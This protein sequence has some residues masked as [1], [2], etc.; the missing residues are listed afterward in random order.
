[1]L[2][3]KFTLKAQDALES[4]TRLAVKLG[5]KHVTP[6][7]LL[8]ACLEQTDG[9]ARRLLTAGHADLE[10][11]ARSIGSLVSATEPADKDSKGTPI[12]R[13]LERVF[14]IAEE[15]A[16]QLKNRY[17]GVHHLLLGLL[18]DSGV[19]AT[20][21]AAGARTTDLRLA[22][23]GAGT[24]SPRKG[25]PT[26]ADSEYLSKYTDD[27]TRAAREG[28]LDPVI[29]RGPEIR[30][31]LQ[32]LN[33][34][35]KNNPLLVG[36]PG[37]G[38]TAVV[39]GLAQRIVADDVPDNLRGVSLLALDLGQ[40]V[41]GTKFRGEFEKRLKA[42][43]NEA[44]DAENVILFIDEIHMIIGAGSSEGSMDASNLL[45]PA[46]SR[47]QI[48][49]VGATTV[50]E[51]RKH[52]EK[53]AALTRRFQRV[54]VNEPD[55]E[56]AINILRGLKETYEAHHGVRVLD[57]AI[58]AAVKLSD[59]YLTDRFLPDKAIDLLDETASS[60]RMDISSKPGEIEDLDRR[61]IHLEIE[62]TALEAEGL[63]TTRERRREI[64]AELVELRARSAELTEV[65]LQE[66]RAIFDLGQVKA[67]LEAARREM[68]Q[69]IREEDFAR[70]AELQYKII[71][72]R[73]QA[74]AEFDDVEVG[75][76]R[77][78][79][80]AV[81]EEDIARTLSR[82]TGIPVD[83]MLDS[84]RER[85]LQMETLMRRRVIGQE[86]ALTATAKAL[87]RSRAGLQD[88][89][90]PIASFLM[91]GPTGVGKTE[92]SKAL[93][94]FMFD[95]ERAL[96]RLDMSE[97]MEKHSVAR[98]VGAPPGYVGFD[99]GGVLTNTI[100]RKPYS[101]VLLDEVEK[102]HPDVFNLLLQV[103]D[104]GRLTDSQG[105]TVDFTNTIIILTS[106]LGTRQLSAETAEGSYEDKKAR[107]MEAVK[108]HFRP[109]FVNRLD[110]II[111]FEALGE[112]SI[113]SIVDIQ[114]RRLG[115]R[116]AD[117]DLRLEVDGE[118]RAELAR[119]GL[120][121]AYGARP[122][123]RVIQNKLADPLSEQILEGTISESQRVLISFADE[124]F[125]ITVEAVEPVTESEEVEEGTEANSED[126]PGAEENTGERS[127]HS[128]EPDERLEVG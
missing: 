89:G 112:E 10:V 65:W 34:R 75:E 14:V 23:E 12:N 7:H 100:R 43:I 25:E 60:L 57:A 5:H 115:D 51:A 45:K 116:L 94:E 106:N 61:V 126:E 8:A 59:R 103:L 56:A 41:A 92:L 11:L 113:G 18:E 128:D 88:P 66:K 17:I 76:T 30:R 105:G 102:A 72:D 49:C 107:V 20:F 55:V 15:R 24:G 83:K 114:L 96:T 85:L 13:D 16:G 78:L 38:K 22:L 80:E 52:I 26:S 119:Q 39:E 48:R 3:E 111:L 120:S 40:L 118:A 124:D 67:D 95:D 122:L 36:E 62:R 50:A 27:L 82:W 84:E 123:K 97:Y 6:G 31:V 63:D 29:G 21:A 58:T 93:A 108:G 54:D 44:I 32:I 4:A 98:L 73:E 81:G 46:L 74:L 91:V 127:R 37:V 19:A 33:R 47:G 101:V 90:R 77:F 125:T 1:M 68:E 9:P 64:E 121:P 87:R 35:H 109:E 86:A 42:V 117:R 99:E 110:D 28:K 70:V 69:R 79:R 2:I 104:D 71:P 53:D